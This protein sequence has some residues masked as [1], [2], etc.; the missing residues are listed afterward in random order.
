VTLRQFIACTF[1]VLLFLPVVPA[2]G[3]DERVPV[4]GLNLCAIR[5]K[6]DDGSK[7]ALKQYLSHFSRNDISESS[8]G[9]RLDSEGFP[10]IRPVLLNSSISLTQRVV[11]LGYA[12]WDPSAGM[13]D[14]DIWILASTR[15][16]SNSTSVQTV[17]KHVAVSR[18]VRF[19]FPWS[20]VFSILCGGSTIGIVL[21]MS[22]LSPLLAPRTSIA[23]LCDGGQRTKIRGVA[24]PVEQALAIANT[25][26]MAIAYRQ[27]TRKYRHNGWQL[28]AD[29]SDQIPCI[30]DDGTGSIS[31]D[32]TNARVHCVNTVKTY[33]NIPGETGNRMPYVDDTAVQVRYIPV[34]AVVT[35]IG[36]LSES[37]TGY[38]AS[39]RVQVFAGDER[40]EVRRLRYLLGM[41]VCVLMFSCVMLYVLRN[42]S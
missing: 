26:V 9:T 7:L 32:I 20:I 23:S 33:N 2:L 40:A 22:K 11:E 41:S 12:D 16:T 15:S 1:S 34:G 18:A 13:F 37:E 4:L 28:I 38:R 29:V 21:T 42:S 35:V 10:C 30:I 14:L 3:A 24:I 19:S 6:S 39:G 5:A 27:T 8:L 17:D 31:L 25:D 36:L